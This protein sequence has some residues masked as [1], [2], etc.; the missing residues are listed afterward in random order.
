MALGDA[1]VQKQI[2]HMVAFIDQEAS[3]KV[4]EIE[5]KAEEEFNIEKGRLVQQQRVK[6]MESYDRKEKQIELNKK[7]QNSNLHNQSRLQ[8]LKA[9]EDHINI[10][11]EETR[12][13]LT[14]LTLNKNNYKTLLGGLITQGLIRLLEQKV[15]LRCRKMDESLVEAAIPD[16]VSE[17]K[18]I[19][20]KDVDL[21]V[22][23]QN[24]LAEDCTGG[25]ELV[26]QGGKFKVVNTLES[27]LELVSSQMMPK[28]REM[29]F[30]SNNNRKF[31]D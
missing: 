23:T 9:K 1:E 16:A 21:K 18:N 17:Y 11:L 4:E 3:E 19:I 25:I 30:G 13:N 8:V 24:Y 20:K 26:A 14:A 28:L 6:I 5:L 15:L 7:I 31:F 10:L 29:L 2:E 27:R 12:K 22:D